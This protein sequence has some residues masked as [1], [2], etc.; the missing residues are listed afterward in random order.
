MSAAATLPIVLQDGRFARFEKV[1]WWDQARLR[2]ARVLVIGAGAIGNE[3]VKNLALLGIG[4]LAIADMDVIE[5]SNLSRSALFRESDAGKPKAECAARAA[6]EIYPDLDVRAIV[7]NVT[8]SLG[9]GW[10]R[11]ADVVVGALDN[12]EARIFVNSACARV[13]RP[14]VDGGIEVLQGVARGFSPPQ[15]ACYEC[16]MSDVDWRVVNTRRSCSMLA[17]RAL[18]HG[19]TPTTPTTASVIGAIE[20]QEVVKILHGLPALLGKGFVF[21]GATH[22][23]YSVSYT[24]DPGCP[25]HEV[26]AP[27]EVLGDAGWNT[28]LTAVWSAAEALLGGVDALEL[29][30]EIVERLECLSCGESR[31]LLRP[32]EGVHDD[33]AACL[34]CGGDA[35]P[36]FLHSIATGSAYAERSARELGLPPWDI[37]WARR[38]DRFHGF[39]LASEGGVW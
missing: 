19:G 13:G 2:D 12:R 14:W 20:A 31:L 38:G 11:R 1:E 36:H 21:E 24:V 33:E 35:T 3:V 34:R 4:H 23:S 17:R 32:I 25:W 30:R 10:F 9:L 22:S 29:G 39:E 5:L 27:I 15:T 26:V 18:A 28:P 7:C 37:I 6:R 8:A 16:T